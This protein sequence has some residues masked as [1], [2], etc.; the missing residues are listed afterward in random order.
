MHWGSAE[1]QQLWTN[2]SREALALYDGHGHRVKELT[3]LQEAFGDRPRREVGASVVRL[4]TSPQDL[5]CLSVDGKMHL[6]GPEQC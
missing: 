6:F 3:A 4:G 2:T 1:T 5:L